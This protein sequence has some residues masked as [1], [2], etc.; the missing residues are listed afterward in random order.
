[1]IKATVVLLVAFCITSVLKRRSAAERHLLW[2]AAIAA[3]AVLPLLGL[4][5]PTWEPAFAQRVTAALPTISTTFSNP[6]STDSQ[7]TFRSERIEPV[8]LGR[9]WSIIWFAGSIIGLLI[10][11]T[12]FIQQRRI[13][14]QSVAYVDSRLS[15]EMTE[16]ARRIGCDRSVRLRRGPDGSMPMT[17]GTLRPQIFIPD[18][19]KEWSRERMRVVVAHELAH[20]QRLDRLFQVISQIACAVYWFNPLFWIASNR[21]YQESEQACD[22]VVIKLGTDASEYASHL[23]EIARNFRCI[24]RVWS[25]TLP[26]AKPSTLERRF[27]ALLKSKSNRNAVTPKGVLSVAIVTLLIALPLAA[28]HVSHTAVASD[29]DS[30]VPTVDQYTIPPLYSDEARAQGIEGNVTVEVRIAGEGVVK[31]VQVVKGLGH[32]LDENALLAVRDWRFIPARRNGIPVEASTQIDVEFN[33][34]NAELNEEIANDMAMRIGPGVVP[35]QIVH[36]VEPQYSVASVEERTGSVI[37]DAVILEDGIPKIIRVIQSMNWE[38][39]EV[40]INALKQWRFSPAMKD[41]TPVRVRMNIAVAFNS[42]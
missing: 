20:V 26:M 41:G 33:L 28:M 42:K 35:P 15:S 1:M 7:V 4:L 8:L 25:P 16:M 14:R 38:L 30:A 5:V 29:S 18:C 10:V 17:C 19:A 2:V 31:R 37:L 23:L 27:A 21:L 34:R 11:G 32:G 13:A 39:D 24:E 22:D 40:A 3:A 6:I 9:V 12:G 36:R